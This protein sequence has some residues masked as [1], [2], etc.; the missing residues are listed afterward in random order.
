MSYKIFWKDNHGSWLDITR[1][2]EEATISMVKEWL[3]NKHVYGLRISKDDDLLWEWIGNPQTGKDLE[4]VLTKYKA[5]KP[6]L[7]I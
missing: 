4:I 7:E 6:V 2:T 5:G 3:E 1:D